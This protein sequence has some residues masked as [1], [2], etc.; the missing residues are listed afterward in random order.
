MKT[1]LYRY[2]P[3]RYGFFWLVL[4]LVGA[5]AILFYFL[6]GWMRE[7]AVS[8]ETHGATIRNIAFVSAGILALVL[9]LWRS[10]VAERQA[11]T[12]ETQAET[13]QQTLLHE[14]FRQG[15]D[16]L[17][18]TTMA[19]RLGGIYSL[20]RLAAEHPEQFYVQVAKSLC[21][22][23]RNPPEG[24]EPLVRVQNTRVD[25]NG[26]AKD[27]EP[28][29]RRESI[30]RLREDV[31]EAL[32]VLGRSTEYQKGLREDAGYEL[33]LSFAE[34]RGAD[35]VRTDFSGV[36]FR[37]ANL[38]NAGSRRSGLLENRHV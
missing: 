9:A 14:R 34:L 11:D 30:N 10:W 19:T 17:G 38:S 28:R 23:V 5:M 2:M 27:D 31:Q 22:F 6:W 7:G 29:S 8:S 20:E 1:R 21:A 24:G 16:M 33:D 15:V 26:N 3:Q 13:S 4:L 25:S 32:G 18:S 37:A 36:N 12:S 35:F